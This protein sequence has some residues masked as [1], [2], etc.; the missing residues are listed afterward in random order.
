MWLVWPP[1]LEQPRWKT[2]HSCHSS[3]NVKNGGV[4]SGI[5]ANKLRTATTVAWWSSS[6]TLFGVLL[7]F[8]VYIFLVVINWNIS[9]CDIRIVPIEL[10]IFKSCRTS[11]W[12]VW[13][14]IFL[15]HFRT[16]KWNTQLICPCH[17][18]YC[19]GLKILHPQCENMI[20]GWNVDHL[21]QKFFPFFKLSKALSFPNIFS[22]F[23][24]PNIIQNTYFAIM[25]G[26]SQ[27][28]NYCKSVYTKI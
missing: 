14:T 5:M 4:T 8:F 20:G 9:R 13:L 2:D 22:N 10:I 17:Y 1:Q 24:L 6:W 18:E 25:S 28:V 19:Y 27:W 23:M 3:S 7:I 12:N 11:K 16:L 21:R 26:I 15:I